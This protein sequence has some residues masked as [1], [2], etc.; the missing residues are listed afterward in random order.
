MRAHTG[1]KTFCCQMCGKIFSQSSTLTKDIRTHTGEKPYCCQK[2]GK[3]FSL[4]SNLTKHIQTQT[5]EKRHYCQECGKKFYSPATWPRICEH[6]LEKSLIVA[7]SEETFSYAASL[8]MNMRT[9]TE[10]NPYCCSECG[11]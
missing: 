10:V 1:Q 3:I 6:N 7:R 2:C 8:T 5:E 9:H 11:K 4:S